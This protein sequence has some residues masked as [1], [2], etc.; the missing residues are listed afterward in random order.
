[1]TTEEELRANLDAAEK[2]AKGWEDRCRELMAMWPSEE[3][4]Q[5]LLLALAKLSI[6]RPGWDNALNR[7]ALKHDDGDE[8][9]VMYDQFRE[10]HKSAMTPD[11]WSELL[12]ACIGLQ[13][14]LFDDDAKA[15][16]E[17][18][19]AIFIAQNAILIALIKPLP[20][21]L[22]RGIVIWK[23][24]PRAG[25]T[26]DYDRECAGPDG[27]EVAVV[28]PSDGSP[29]EHVPFEQLREPTE[30][31]WDRLHGEHAQDLARYYKKPVGV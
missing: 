24:G 21:A 5:M 16:V 28:Y 13:R 20:T 1:M 3:E 12:R 8:R 6:E 2:R 30:A 26:G 25:Q 14:A 22:L 27:E 19:N 17:R 7:F 10:M 29:V 9:A 31:E 11:K 23:T 15:G 4:R 18:D